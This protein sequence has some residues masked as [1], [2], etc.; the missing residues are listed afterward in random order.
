MLKRWPAT[1]IGAEFEDKGRG[2][3]YDCFGLVREVLQKE[4]QITLPSYTG[5]YSTAHELAQAW[6]HEEVQLLCQALD[7]FQKVT[8]AIAGD[9][10][11]FKIG[12]HLNHCGVMINH[13]EFLHIQRGTHACLNYI[14]D[15]TWVHIREGFYRHYSRL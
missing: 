9:V 2:P 6:V 15:F 13:E 7:G 11:M 10:V 3:K 4:F 12:K 14:T 8:L 5:E 1:Y